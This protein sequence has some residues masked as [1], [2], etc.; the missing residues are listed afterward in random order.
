MRV[1]CKIRKEPVYRREAFERGLRVTGFTLHDKPFKPD[2]PLD[3]LVI[4]NRKRGHDEQ[5]AQQWELRGGKVIVA[6]NGY[7]QRQD[8]TTYAIS[9]G[10][11]NG[12]GDF[13]VHDEDRF[14]KLGFPLMPWRTSEHFTETVIRLQRGIGSTLMA[15]PSEWPTSTMR[16]VE[17]RSHG[18]VRIIHH[19]GNFAPRVPPEKDLQ[20]AKQFIT[21]GSSMGVLALTLGIPVVYGAPHWICEEGASRLS[22]FPSLKMDYTARDAAMHRMSW[23]QWHFD[24]IATGEPFARIKDAL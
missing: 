6:E 4:W 23:G 15:S 16:F 10:Q 2:G 20:F 3:W 17:A 19:P 12:A 24:E 7:L 11:H 21:W 22:D 1:L 8:K 9:I 5:E 18:P 14:T 13:P